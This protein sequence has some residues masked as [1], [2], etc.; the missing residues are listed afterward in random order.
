[1]LH[2]PRS[3]LAPSEAL[4]DPGD[5]RP[6]PLSPMQE[7]I[8]VIERLER[9]SPLNN[10]P[11]LLCLTGPLDASLLTAALHHIVQRHDAL[12]LRIVDEPGR[13]FGM[14]LHTEAGPCLEHVD[15]SGL[16]MGDGEAHCRAAAEAEAKRPF[17]IEC[18]PL[19]RAVLYR[20]SGDR[21]FLFLNWHHIIID[22]RSINIILRE[23]AQVYAALRAG[24]EPVLP[25]P[26]HRFREFSGR[27]CKRADDGADQ[28][29]AW[30]RQHLTVTPHSF[31]LPSDR[32]AAAARSYRGAAVDLVLP[33]ALVDGLRRVGQRHGTSLF[34]VL[35]AGYALVAARWR[36][37]GDA[38]I[39]VVASGRTSDDMADLVGVFLNLLPLRVD[40]AA[41]A[42]LGQLLDAVAEHL[43]AGVRH[44]DMPLEDI[45]GA[46]AGGRGAAVPQMAINYRSY[47]ISAFT[48]LGLTASIRRLQ[49]DTALFPLGLV[50][51][52]WGD[53]LHVYLEYSTEMFDAATIERL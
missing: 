1:M 52:K 15:L 29:R 31:D 27:R 45:L 17:D 36:G 6:W 12:R 5:E 40:V 7:R 38:V 25:P 37:D 32:P 48:A 2:V 16:A 4:A 34:A 53:E 11:F 35:L 49:T 14:V 41:Q 50:A 9:G 26:P 30:W 21:H 22:G 8:A 18:D 44:Q 19:M 24:A 3:D 13:G 10:A 43:R 28:R 39:G 23:M 20:L 42:S 51:E 46:A 33:G 47:D